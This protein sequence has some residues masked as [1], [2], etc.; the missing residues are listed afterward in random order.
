MKVDTPGI[1]MSITLVIAFSFGVQLAFELICV[2]FVYS[3]EE[4]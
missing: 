2:K 1:A 4:Y 3:Q